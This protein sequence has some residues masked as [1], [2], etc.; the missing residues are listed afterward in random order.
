MTDYPE[1]TYVEQN[2]LDYAGRIRLD[3]RHVLVLGA[4]AG[5]GRQTAFAMADLGAHV[6]CVDRDIA[7]AEAIAAEI[8]GVPISADATTHE[9]IVQILRT[10]TD[11]LG[12]LRGV[13][14]IIGIAHHAPLTETGAAVFQDMARFNLQHAYLLL[15]ELPAYVDEAGASVAFVSSI[16]G[17]RSAPLHAAYGAMKAGLI[18]LVGSAAVEL[19]PRIR[20][21]SVAPGQT[22]TERMV[23]RHQDDDGY[24]QRSREVPAGRIGETD[25]IASALLYFV[26]DLSSWVTGQTLVV[27][28]GAGRMYQYR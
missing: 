7:R 3:G 23:A 25:D 16:S 21:N 22:R 4:G 6:S 5:I 11:R 2:A 18:N 27:D 20:V 15:A 28:G 10:A 13:A 9:G 24:W 19:G 8:G 12:P 26:S 17:L 14:D 1:K